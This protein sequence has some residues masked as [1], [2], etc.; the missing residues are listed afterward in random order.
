M[1]ETIRE[2]RFSKVSNSSV[3]IGHKIYRDIYSGFGLLSE[4]HGQ[5]EHKIAGFEI[6]QLEAK[7]RKHRLFMR[8]W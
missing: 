4:F 7:V 6:F 5:I 3:I 2:T 1:A 8:V